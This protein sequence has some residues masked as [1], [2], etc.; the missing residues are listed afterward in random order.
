MCQEDVFQVGDNNRRL[1]SSVAMSS[2]HDCGA[3]SLHT[4]SIIVSANKMIMMMQDG[5]CVLVAQ[6]AAAA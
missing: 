2:G 6:A 1:S 4:A 3:A 5:V